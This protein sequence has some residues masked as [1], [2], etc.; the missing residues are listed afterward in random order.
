MLNQLFLIF[1]TGIS[2]MVA[3]T[4]LHKIYIGKVNQLTTLHNNISPDGKWKIMVEQNKVQWI[5]MEEPKY[6]YT[7]QEIIEAM[8]TICPEAWIDESK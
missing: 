4:V 6:H 1:D 7:T 5:D 3:Y 8:K 2:G